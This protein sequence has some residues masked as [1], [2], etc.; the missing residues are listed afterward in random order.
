[1][2]SRRKTRLLACAACRQAWH[3]V[4]DERCRDELRAAEQLADGGIS[5]LALQAASLGAELAYEDARKSAGSEVLRLYAAISLTAG[6]LFPSDVE[7][8]FRAIVDLAPFRKGD[9][10]AAQA[11]LIR[12]IVGNPFRRITF[13]VRWFTTD[14]RLLAE[15]VY[16]ANAFDRLPILADALQDAG[17]DSDDLLSHLRDPHATHVRGCW[18]LDLVLGKS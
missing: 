5:D 13:D 12:E 6:D 1:L 18:A 14:V 17:C 10:R 15:W 16:A 3:E 9:A 11:N 2:T 4:R 7:A 8:I